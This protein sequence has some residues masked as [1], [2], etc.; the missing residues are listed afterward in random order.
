MRIRLQRKKAISFMPECKT[1]ILSSCPDLQRKSIEELKNKLKLLS[2]DKTTIDSVL[3]DQSLISKMVELLGGNDV[4]IIAHVA[5][6][7]C[8]LVGGNRQTCDSHRMAKAIMIA[9][10]KLRDVLTIPLAGDIAFRYSVKENAL[11]T[12]SNLAAEDEKFQVEILRTCGSAMKALSF[13]I[14]PE[15]I[16]APSA[17]CTTL[18]WLILNLLNPPPPENDNE[19]QKKAGQVLFLLPY[20]LQSGLQ[21]SNAK[22]LI[23]A[24]K[25]IESC[26]NSMHARLICQALTDSDPKACKVFGSDSL[27]GCLAHA[28]AKVSSAALGCIVRLCSFPDSSTTQLFD[29]VVKYHAS[30]ENIDHL[31][32]LLQSTNSSGGS[33]AR[34]LLQV[35]EHPNQ[36][37]ESPASAVAVAAAAAMAALPY[38]GDAQKASAAGDRGAVRLI[39][40]ARKQA[41]GEVPREV[42]R[43]EGE[44]GGGDAGPSA[45]SDDYAKSLEQQ[46]G[47]SNSTAGP[48]DANKPNWWTCVLSTAEDAAPVAKSQA[49]GHSDDDSD[50][51]SDATSSDDD[52]DGGYL[53]EYD[54]GFGGVRTA[55]ADVEK[56]ELTCV[57]R[58]MSPQTRSL[59][60]Q[61]KESTSASNEAIGQ[62]SDTVGIRADS[63]Q[64]KLT[65]KQRRAQRKQQQDQKREQEKPKYTQEELQQE[66]LRLEEEK[67]QRLQNRKK[68]VRQNQQR[69]ASEVVGRCAHLQCFPALSASGLQDKEREQIMCDEER[70]LLVCSAGCR[71]CYHVQC[72]KQVANDVMSGA[73]NSEQSF[74]TLA[75]C[76]QC[77]TSDCTTNVIGGSDVNESSIIKATIWER[78]SN[79]E[80][81]GAMT[82]RVLLK[83]KEKEHGQKQNQ[84]QKQQKRKSVAAFKQNPIKSRK[85]D[86]KLTRKERLAQKNQGKLKDK[87]AKPKSPKAKSPEATSSET[88]SEVQKPDQTI[89][90]VL[91]KH[92]NVAAIKAF[93]ANNSSF[94]RG[95]SGRKNARSEKEM[96]IGRALKK[97]QGREAELL[98]KLQT[99][100]K[101]PED[102]QQCKQGKEGKGKGKGKVQHVK[103]S[104][105]KPAW[106]RTQSSDAPME[107]TARDLLLEGGTDIPSS[108]IGMVAGHSGSDALISVGNISE[109]SKDDSI[110]TWLE[111]ARTTNVPDG[112][113][114]LFE[115]EK[116]NTEPNNHQH[117]DV[118]M[119]ARVA[120]DNIVRSKDFEPQL[121]EDSD[122]NFPHLNPLEYEGE[123]E[124]ITVA[125]GADPAAVYTQARLLRMHH[126]A[127]K[128]NLVSKQ[129]APTQLTAESSMESMLL[130]DDYEW[131][132]V[133]RD[134]Q[135]S[136]QWNEVDR[137]EVDRLQMEAMQRDA[138]RK[139]VDRRKVEAAQHDAQH[140]KMECDRLQVEAASAHSKAAMAQ[141]N[142]NSMCTAVSQHQHQ[143]ENGHGYNATTEQQYQRSIF[144]QQQECQYQNEN[145]YQYGNQYQD[146]FDHN[147]VAE[148]LSQR[149]LSSY[150]QGGYPDSY[151]YEQ[152][153]GYQQQPPPPN[154]PLPP[155][156]RRPPPKPTTL[157]LPPKPC[158][159]PEPVTF[160]QPPPACPPK[161]PT[162]AKSLSPLASAF[163]SGIGFTESFTPV[164]SSSYL[165]CEPETASSGTY[166]FGA[167]TSSI[168]KLSGA[169]DQ[170]QTA[171]DD[172]DSSNST[173]YNTT[174]D[175]TTLL[176]TDE[177]T[178]GKVVEFE[179]TDEAA[180]I[181]RRME[182]QNEA[183][184]KGSKEEQKMV[185]NN[186]AF[187]P[188]Y[189]KSKKPVTQTQ[190]SLQVRRF[191]PAGTYDPRLKPG[192]WVCE[193]CNSSNF[194]RRVKCYR[195]DRVNQDHSQS[196]NSPSRQTKM[197]IASKQKQPDQRTD[198][199]EGW[200]VVGET[201]PSNHSTD[202]PS[203]PAPI[204]SD[205]RGEGWAC[206][207]CTM[208]NAPHVKC[209]D[210]CATPRATAPVTS[211]PPTMA[212]NTMAATL[213]ECSKVWTCRDCTFENPP[214]FL[215]CGV[216]DKER[217]K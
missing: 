125:D 140:L 171:L 195:C 34:V 210:M 60:H 85:K 202:H 39:F 182:N 180:I 69:L 217:P 6:C 7:L 214:L 155:L 138:Q 73:K 139:E 29:R 3:S 134:A 163:D 88:K 200:A 59:G 143:Y 19:L 15:M 112:T 151:G 186:G 66:S 16:T 36:E 98:E 20:L 119:A 58:P 181:M 141:N 51:S 172:R 113:P 192:D 99:T 80:S 147:V 106:F 54:C 37:Y 167:P 109:N 23:E 148:P 31:R 168:L 165:N 114:E 56:H 46:N 84:K 178:F 137:L 124:C 55:P 68:Q 164:E 62:L 91:S 101:K 205:G 207:A 206:G 74:E 183:S 215:N 208:H 176:D 116:E 61:E 154:Y 38:G 25:P 90:K 170:A 193:H 9:V 35:W 71:V 18:S 52:D 130:K 166:D 26:S 87:N 13:L 102:I 14:D 92:E 45:N 110:L 131:E 190:A 47:S 213:V 81:E 184:K 82:E 216:C 122:S 41:A 40:L 21:S 10:P 209:C 212:T 185:F 100:L 194:Q 97:Y 12:L 169:V 103:I 2:I 48:T 189:N 43:E 111:K 149:L 188:S 49:W 142:L 118:A 177:P 72:W 78:K 108:G 70:V 8:S 144:Q 175:D 33:L 75:C 96:V 132:A 42:L 135:L 161:S 105:Y 63:S 104:K 120:A 79:W 28:D 128:A 199:R 24:C 93:Y 201:Q 187:K 160:L 203:M 157:P 64:L 5:E 32:T 174:C 67:Q 44:G 57:L 197:K 30:S 162:I 133:Q 27:L 191:G 76:W 123:K 117:E 11:W 150:Y 156:Q 83:L 95:G 115:K 129:D 4:K 196:Q 86:G 107:S 50:D 22:C 53:C 179:D 145:Q 1:G 65:K 136:K 158:P 152:D 173:G 126:E 198:G 204:P 121:C 127:S 77:P 94:L 153:Y 89:R 159:P 211:P 17:F 146:E